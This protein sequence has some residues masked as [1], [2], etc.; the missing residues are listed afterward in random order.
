M[1]SS[2]SAIKSRTKEV[3]IIKLLIR[4]PINKKEITLTHQNVFD[5]RMTI[6]KATMAVNFLA[7]VEAF[8]MPVNKFFRF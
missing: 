4:T 6:R 1:P 5:G 2:F 3:Q 8:T 7:F